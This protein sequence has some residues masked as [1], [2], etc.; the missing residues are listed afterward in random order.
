MVRIP[1]MNWPLL[2]SRTVS[3]A[4]WPGSDGTESCTTDSPFFAS[5][6][7][8]ASHT[9]PRSAYFDF[10]CG[11]VFDLIASLNVGWAAQSA[12]ASSFSCSD[13]SI[14]VLQHHD[15]RKI[16]AQQPDNIGLRPAEI[17]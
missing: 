15:F 3:I 17:R 1:L 14:F 12:A 11:L 8:A 4:I 9:A 6:S 5:A 10:R 13:R 7:F 16:P 2:W